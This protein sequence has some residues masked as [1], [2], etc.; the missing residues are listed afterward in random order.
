MTTSLVDPRRRLRG[1]RARHAQR[2]RGAARAARRPPPLLF[3]STNKVYGGLDRRRAAAR[4]ARATSRPT[5]A[6]R[7]RGIG[8]ERPLDFHS[9]YGCSKGAADQYVLDYARSYGLPA[10]RVPHELH[11]RAAPV[12]HR[13]PG[14]GR[15]L[16]H[17]RA[18]AASRSPST[19]TAR[20]CATSCSS[21]ISSRRSCCARAAHRP[22][23]AARR[24]TSA[25][26]PATPISLLELLDLIERAARQRPEVRFEDWRAGRPALLRLGHSRFA[27]ATGWSPRVNAR[28]GVGKLYNWLLEYRGLAAGPMKAPAM[29]EAHAS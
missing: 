21:T 12:R 7:A 6:L 4:A 2:A 16:P 9:P 17:P 10:A 27:A 19:A 15:A 20:R 29:A 26:G 25:A 23:R 22:A 14:L 1:Q 8:E 18:R 3:T 11:L 24:S 5:A 13:G 28:Q